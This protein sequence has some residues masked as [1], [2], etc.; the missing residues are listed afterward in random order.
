[1]EINHITLHNIVKWVQKRIYS[2]KFR[3][4]ET[5]YSAYSTDT[6]KKIIVQ[7]IWIMT[8]WGY[9]TQTGYHNPPLLH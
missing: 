5:L 6:F 2:G 3:A 9:H 4:I 8:K 1:M 7:D